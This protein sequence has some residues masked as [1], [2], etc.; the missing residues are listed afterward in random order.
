MTK[1]EHHKA[2]KKKYYW[3]F[4]VFGPIVIVIA[5]MIIGDINK[6]I[7]AQ[8]KLREENAVLEAERARL[9]ADPI[10]VNGIYTSINK[11]RSESGA[12]AL[13]TLSNLTDA[14]NQYCNYMV[15]NN[16]FDYKNPSDGKNSNSFITDNMGDQYYKIAVSS[17]FKGDTETETA[18]DVAKKAASA[19][20]VNIN[21]PAYNSVGWATCRPLDKPDDIYIVGMFIE[22][23]DR[24]VVAQPAY[25]PTYYSSPTSCYTTYNDYG[26]YLSPTATTRCY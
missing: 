14:A 20:A 1:P 11:I 19:Q 21:N 5:I 7:A 4:V 18:G 10:N 15:V 9:A 12:P 22:K 26:G 8:N 17:I 23:A 16:F 24:P 3:P 6:S 13:Q 25:R 2:E